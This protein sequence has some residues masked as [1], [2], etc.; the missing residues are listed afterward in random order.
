MPT[1]QYLQFS[2]YTSTEVA[3]YRMV[4]VMLNLLR[5]HTSAFISQSNFSQG[6]TPIRY[7]RKILLLYLFQSETFLSLF[8]FQDV[9]RSDSKC[10]QT[11]LPV[12]GTS[13]LKK[14]DLLHCMCL[15]M[16]MN[17]CSQNCRG[18]SNAMPLSAPLR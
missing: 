6:V 3:V 12:P 18:S 15:Y 10:P 8:Y 7:I 2:E 5:F 17:T 14:P 4:P 11:T 13:E 16:V 9:I 1:L